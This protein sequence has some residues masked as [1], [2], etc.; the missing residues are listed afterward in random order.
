MINDD[1]FHYSG[2]SLIMLFFISFVGVV[3]SCVVSYLTGNI[4]VALLKL[5]KQQSSEGKEK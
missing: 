3:G 5:K 4:R 2:T 1:L